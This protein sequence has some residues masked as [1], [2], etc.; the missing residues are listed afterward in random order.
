MKGYNINEI[1][2][3][4]KH[5]PKLE[6]LL[7]GEIVKGL[8]PHSKIKPNSEIEKNE[9]MQFPDGTTQKVVG[10]KHET[11]GV[12][13]NIPD[14]TK[15]VTN[16]INLTPKQVKQIEAKYKVPVSTKDTYATVIDK[17][18][19]KIG[20]TKLA[21]EQEE[22]FE[23][24][25]KVLNSE[26]EKSTLSINKE[27]LSKKINDIEKRKEDKQKE[28]A[29][30]FNVVFDMQ[31]EHKASTD[32][33]KSDEGFK[34][35]GV[36][37]RNFEAV[38]KKFG[39]TKAQGEKMMKYGGDYRKFKDGG[40]PDDLFKG[41]EGITKQYNYIKNLAQK[42]EFIDN[43]YK[44]YEEAFESKEKQSSNYYKVR[45]TDKYKKLSK[46]EVVENF[47]KMQERNLALKAHG[48]D[49]KKI[50]NRASDKNTSKYL[51]DFIKE[52]KLDQKGIEIP[53]YD[54]TA[55]EQLAYIAFNDLVEDYKTNP[56]NY[57]NVPELKVFKAS[58]I[59]IGDEKWGQK[60]ISRADGIYTD[61]TA[62]QIS[63]VDFEQIKET[64]VSPTEPEKQ[65]EKKEEDRELGKTEGIVD[66]TKLPRK[67]N[68]PRLFF[69][70]DQSALP[71]SPMEAH[72]KA[73][74]RLG[75][76]DP[77]RLGIEG[78]LQQS[79]TQRQFMSEQLD[80]LPPALRASA[81]ANLLST[82]QASTNKA[83]LDTNVVNAQN[84]AQAELFNIQQ[85]DQESLY[86]ANNALDF[87][88]RQMKAKANTEEELKRYYDYNRKVNI[89]NFQNQQRLNLLDSIYP[90][91]DLDFMGMTAQFD[92]SSEWTLED[93]NKYAQSI[94][95]A[96][97]AINT[98]N[99]YEQG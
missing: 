21:E 18:L 49:Y 97:P 80:S 34:F 24:L 98:V 61:T 15:I 81:L 40:E 92:P 56:D 7:T 63:E 90:D 36:S 55:Q 2:V 26:V 12:K 78:Q 47:I 14:G 95:G 75:R 91:F 6:E 45:G 8:D 33:Y 30:F 79:A 71:P 66:K 32:K 5:T 1:E 60:N 16:S 62:G 39:I 70:P 74:V 43:L 65:E 25:K 89:N 53:G 57:S 52:N 84:Q 59:G 64:P 50:Q 11:G 85:A 19:K 82:D 88:A 96:L 67:P 29:E 58:P 48:V 17:Y 94:A 22:V 46:Q 77:V 73:D 28:K 20:L 23:Q 54:Q 41:D 4:D 35:G 27:Y 10:Q 38:C 51:K 37:D 9:Y 87:E 44:K 3:I 31:E 93:R 13:M 86:S 76:I 83:I 69:T 42:P 72:L 68:V 99:R